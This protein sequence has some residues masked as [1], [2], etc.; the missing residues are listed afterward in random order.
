MKKIF[1]FTDTELRTRLN[2]IRI[3]DHKGHLIVSGYS[4]EFKKSFKR[5][6][7]IKSKLTKF[8]RKVVLIYFHKLIINADDKDRIDLLRFDMG[9]TNYADVFGSCF[10]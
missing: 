8:E 10:T 4:K 7:S 5:L 3:T 1:K 9:H 2:L 6:T